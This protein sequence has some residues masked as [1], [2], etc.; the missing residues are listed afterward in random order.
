MN[1][2]LILCAARIKRVLSEDR[3]NAI[4]AEAGFFKRLRKFTPTRAIWLFVTAMASGTTNSLAGVVRLFADLCGESMSYKAFHDRLSVPGFPEFLRSSLT[5]FMT[6]LSEPIR[7]GRSRYLKR[8]TDIVVQD[9]SS[10]EVNDALVDHFPGRFTKISPAA[11]EVHCTYS[12]YDGQPIAVAVAPDSETERDFLPEPEEVAGKLIL[13]DKG[14]TSYE[15]PARVK[16]AGGDFLGRMSHKAFNPKILKCYRG[17]FK[18]HNAEGLTLRDLELPKSNVDLLI[19][20]KGHRLRLVIYYVRRK[21]VHVYLLTTLCP[22]AFPPSIVAALYRLRWQVEL[23]FKECKSFTNLRKFQTKDPYIVE[24]LVW[25]SMLAV[26][27]RRFLLYSAF[28]NTGKHCAPFI[29]ADLSW[30]FFRDLG[31]IGASKLR[32]LVK[33]LRDIL[34]LLRNTAER[35]NPMQQNTFEIVDIEP[36]ISCG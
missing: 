12:L 6:E 17:P 11:I 2:N 1:Q 21:D 30:T 3:I 13:G 19:E 25:A 14:Y 28:R 34:L 18:N 32:G 26:L 15:Y 4:G 29:A 33:T 5:F 20:G 9:G 10:F 16:A 8:F 27:V 22:R 23:F 7:H 36:V 24:G 35:T 31:R